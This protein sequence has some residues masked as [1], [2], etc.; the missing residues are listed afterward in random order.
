MDLFSSLFVVAA[1]SS[2]TDANESTDEASD[3]GLGSTPDDVEPSREA[4]SLADARRLLSGPPRDALAFLI[5]ALT[6]PFLVCVVAAGALAADLAGSWTEVLVWG[7]MAGVFAGVVP[8]LIVYA[9]FRRGKLT[10]M[11]V[12]VKEQRWV[13]LGASI[14]SGTLGLA[15]LAVVKAPDKLLAL[16]AGYLANAIIFIVISTYWKASLHAAV[17][18]GAFVGCALVV[19]PWWW[20]GLLGLPAVMWARSRRGRHTPAQGIVGA[21]IAVTTMT[22]TYYAFMGIWGGGGPG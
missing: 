20:L 1:T 17:Y 14:L 10:D 18:C 13:P 12:A 4:N 5:S 2:A 21:F 16:T 11:H 22:A 9:M 7:I 8:F 19:S 6:S 15:A 3:E